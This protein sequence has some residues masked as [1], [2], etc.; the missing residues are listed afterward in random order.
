MRFSLFLTNAFFFVVLLASGQAPQ[1]M[2]YQFV[3]R[4]DSGALLSEQDVGVR[5]SIVQGDSGMEVYSE[6]HQITTNMNGAG[7]LEIGAGMTENG[8]FSLIKWGQGPFDIKSEVD[9]EG[10]SNYSISGLSQILSVPYALY[11]ENGFTHQ[12]GEIA[13][14]GIIFSM[15]KDSVGVEHGLVASLYDVS[16]GE[17]WGPL[18]EDS[19]A[20][21]A[22]NG[23]LNS[24]SDIAGDACENFEYEDE[25][26][27]EV[28]DDWYLPALWELTAM[29]K[30]AFILNTT[31]EADGDPQTLGFPED[32]SGVYWSSTE[33]SGTFAWSVQFA[34]GVPST[35][36]KDSAYKV[37]AVRRY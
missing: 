26:S 1:K 35:N 27:G 22:S 12:I 28:Y 24:G 17:E 32:L 10:G 2:S 9:P 36:F 8:N 7:S 3:I 31:L 14:G 11:A 37:R 15:W 20:S 21:S 5:I 6:S 29:S 19:D 33:V 13:E 18:Y 23:T 4:D 34:T 25:I 16:N 30:E